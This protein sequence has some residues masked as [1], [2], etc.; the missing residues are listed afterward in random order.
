MSMVQGLTTTGGG[1]L[2]TGARGMSA[3]DAI[4][5]APNRIAAPHTAAMQ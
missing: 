1:A 5:P 3:A 2:Y 4:A